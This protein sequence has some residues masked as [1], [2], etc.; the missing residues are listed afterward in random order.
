MA[1]TTTSQASLLL[2]K[3]LKGTSWSD[4]FFL[5]IKSRVWLFREFVR[6]NRFVE[7]NFFY[8]MIRSNEESSWRLLSW[9]GRWLQRIWMAG[10]YN[11]TSWY[12][13]VSI[14]VQLSCFNC[15]RCLLLD[16]I[17]WVCTFSCSM[18]EW[19]RYNILRCFLKKKK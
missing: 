5:L 14:S 4:P 6:G 15:N 13:L 12:A 17:L 7:L 10:Y 1:G 19:H 8:V 16:Q 2:Q 18:V 9:I 11:R 3:Q